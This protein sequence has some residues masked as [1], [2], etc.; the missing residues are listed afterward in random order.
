MIPVGEAWTRAIQ[1]GVADPNPYDGIDAGKLDLW[2]YDHY[3]ASTYGYYLEALMA[4]SAS[5]RPRSALARRQ[6]VLGVRAGDV[7]AEVKAL[8]QVAFDQLSA[9]KLLKGG[10]TRSAQKAPARCASER[11]A[12][13]MLTAALRRRP[14]A[15]AARRA[16]RRPPSKCDSPSANGKKQRFP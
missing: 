15:H 1:T 3:H 4:S 2:T 5:H 6:R 8:Q 12:A 10:P 11:D 16:I 14:R 13:A 7:R 9:A